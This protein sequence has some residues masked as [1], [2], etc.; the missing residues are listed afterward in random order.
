[1]ESTIL[2]SCGNQKQVGYSRKLGLALAI[3]A[4]KKGQYVVGSY[5]NKQTE[6]QNLKRGHK[7][8]FSD[9]RTNEQVRA[10]TI[11]FFFLLHNIRRRKHKTRKR[12]I[13][14]NLV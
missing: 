7:K 6:V 3:G 10:D 1:M 9:K 8:R 5:W 2:E 12:R 13:E 11:F 4:S 14:Y